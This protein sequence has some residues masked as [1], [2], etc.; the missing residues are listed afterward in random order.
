MKKRI[1]CSL[2]ILLVC[3]AFGSDLL[4]NSSGRLLRKSELLALV[5]GGV[6]PENVIALIN[7]RGL[8]FRPDNSF[9]SQLEGAGA[10]PVILRALDSAKKTDT[11]PEDQSDKDLLEHLS[12]AGSLINA[13]QYPEAASELTEAISASFASVES[14]FVMG[15]VLAK[16]QRG[17]IELS[18]KKAYESTAT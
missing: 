17:E 18:W 15:Q 2:I 6:L 14:G 3:A 11:A 9:R 12:N 4:A 5:A 13:K 8:S 10:N 1:T 7:N 16:Q